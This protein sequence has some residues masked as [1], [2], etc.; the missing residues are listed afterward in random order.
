MVKIYTGD[1]MISGTG[2]DALALGTRIQVEG[3]R[4][5]G[6]SDF[7]VS[8]PIHL[9]N[10][11]WEP[12]EI[13]IC[14]IDWDM[15]GI[16][17]LVERGRL[18]RKLAPSLKWAPVQHIQDAYDAWDIFKPMLQKHMKKYGR[19]LAWI[20]IENVGQMW[21]STRCDF[22]KM[23]FD[24]PLHQ[25][26]LEARKKAL[27]A[28][29]MTMPEFNRLFDYKVINPMH[30]DLRNDIMFGEFNVIITTH[31]KDLYNKKGEVIGSVGAGQKEND[32]F[33]D[34]IL[35]KKVVEGKEDEKFKADLVGCRY[36]KKGF[37]D[38]DDPTFK[39]FF[40]MI[41]KI[42]ETEQE[43]DFEKFWLTCTPDKMNRPVKKEV[44]GDPDL[45]DDDD[46]EEEEEEEEEIDEIE[47][48]D[49]EW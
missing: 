48:D 7:I 46:W 9:N 42:R 32:G 38:L 31:M 19:H 12:K 18:P 36:T 14:V 11:G 49:E 3:R 24:K 16:V 41:Y 23:V 5:T 47:E 43:D 4:K 26:M 15:G 28:D 8:L 27:A 20:C 45:D 29:K 35:R 39:R 30:N 44:V 40:Q 37:H 25:I 21:E 2:G 13:L 17:P 1:Q 6:K 10:L 34:Y 33:V 22:S